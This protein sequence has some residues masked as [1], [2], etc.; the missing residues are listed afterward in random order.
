MDEV[1]RVVLQFKDGV[2]E[3]QFVGDW[4]GRDIYV[5]MRQLERG[6]RAY[7]AQRRKAAQGSTAVTMAGGEGR[8]TTDSGSTSSDSRTTAQTLTPPEPKTLLSQ[9]LSSR[10]AQQTS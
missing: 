6:Y 7:Q 9:R 4:N 3:T 1:K 5:A 10:K 2:V 8:W